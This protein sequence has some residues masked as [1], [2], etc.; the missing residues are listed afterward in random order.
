MSDDAIRRLTIE[1]GEFIQIPGPNPILKPG[2]EGAWDD[3]I[4]EAS[5]A[6]EEQ[7][8]YY[9]YYHATNKGAHKYRLG[10]ATSDHPLGPFKKY[11]DNPILEYGEEGSWDDTHVACA[12]IMKEGNEKE[13]KYYMW[14]SGSTR[15]HVFSIGLATAD[16]PLG[17]W[18]KYENNPV[19]ED[20][21]YLGGVLKI[22]GKYRIYSA[23]RIHNSDAGERSP[24]RDYHS[25]YSPLGVAISDN[26]EGPFTFT[27]GELLLEKGQK[28][29][30]D[31]GGI[32]EA[33]VSHYNGMYHMFYGGTKLMGP[34]TENI[35]YAYSLDGF[36]WYK[37]GKNPVI[38]RKANPDVAAMAEVH[39][40]IENPFVYLYY[41]LRPENRNGQKFPFDEDLGVSILVTERPFGFDIPIVDLDEMK[42][43][44]KTELEETSPIA[45]DNISR[46]SITAECGYASGARR[47]VTIHVRSSYDGKHYDTSDLAKFTLELKGGQLSRKTFDL[48]PAGRFVKVIIENNDPAH[49]VSDLKIKVSVAG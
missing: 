26:P 46:I 48:K 28:G 40:I 29:D 13:N 34:R 33:E 12:Y 8:I 21:G 3:K 7:G 14:Y 10:V 23:H 15:D 27:E 35:G 18:E 37:Y 42:P 2:P 4:L 36:I 39:S 11:G 5:D 6:F 30:W 45:L 38:P 22:D 16:S 31:E 41:T 20:F 1:Q 44:Q 43:N 47:P 19:V 25:D 32:S 49:S 24:S 9:L 17:P